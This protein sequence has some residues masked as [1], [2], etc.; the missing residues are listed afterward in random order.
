MF[1]NFQPDTLDSE[2]SFKVGKN[3]EVLF[4][5]SMQHLTQTTPRGMAVLGDIKP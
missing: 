3:G 1:C 4:N 2:G 5:A